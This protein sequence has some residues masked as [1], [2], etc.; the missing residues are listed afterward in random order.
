M[1]KPYEREQLL[2]AIQSLLRRADMTRQKI[3]EATVLTRGPLTLQIPQ[4]KAFVNGHDAELTQKEFAVLLLLMQN[5][6]KELTGEA[7]YESVWGTTTGGDTHA[8]RNHISRLRIKLGADNTDAF[9]ISSGYGKG[10]CFTI[11]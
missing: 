1:R 9:T 4:S 10:Y 11:N 8:I 3:A 6:N 2:A 7:I 5:E